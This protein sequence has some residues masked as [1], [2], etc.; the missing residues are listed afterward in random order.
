M[1]STVLDIVFVNIEAE[2]RNPFWLFP[3]IGRGNRPFVTCRLT[4]EDLMKESYED[5]IP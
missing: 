2:I 1:G 4:N 3:S 5:V